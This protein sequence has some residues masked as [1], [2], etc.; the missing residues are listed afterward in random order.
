[1]LARFRNELRAGTGQGRPDGRWTAQLAR[2]PFMGLQTFR[3]E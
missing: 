2:A 1:M 3:R